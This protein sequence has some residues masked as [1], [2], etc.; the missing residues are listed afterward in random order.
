MRHGQAV[1]R[2]RNADAAMRSAGGD[3]DE[4]I[5]RGGGWCRFAKIDD[6][7][8]GAVARRHHEHVTA[9]A[10]VAGRGV[11]DGQ[12]KGG[13][14]RRIDGVAAALER[15]QSDLR[16]RPADAYD[17]TLAAAHRRVERRG[18][19]RRAGAERQNGRDASDDVPQ[20]DRVKAYH[21]ESAEAA[22]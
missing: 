12:G 4:H 21:F 7:A 3:V 16:R 19:C 5:A 8:V 9:A 13:G 2:A 15:L 20:L 22:L 6:E 14:D 17:G 10:D 18:S 1:D 11:R